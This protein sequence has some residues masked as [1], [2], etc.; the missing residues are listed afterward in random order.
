MIYGYSE[1]ICAFLLTVVSGVYFWR[2]FPNK[3]NLMFSD[4]AILA[5]G[6]YFGLAPFVALAYGGTVAADEDES[7]AIRSTY[8]AVLLFLIGLMITKVFFTGALHRVIRRCGG[9]QQFPM[10]WA[11]QH[12]RRIAVITGVAMA[13]LVVAV[14]MQNIA[15][16]GGVGSLDTSEVFE[17]KTYT[18]IVIEYLEL[19]M[20][21]GLA[22]LVIH[23]LLAG[24]NRDINFVL[25]GI[26]CF[27][28][29]LE[30]RRNMAFFVYMTL[31]LIALTGMRL[32]TGQKLSIGLSMLIL[33]FVIFPLFLHMRNLIASYRATDTSFKNPFT[34]IMEAME[35]QSQAGTTIAADEDYKE[36]IV[37]RILETR[38]FIFNLVQAQKDREPMGGMAFVDSVQYSLPRSFREQLFVGSKGD[39]EMYYGF[40]LGDAA[41]SIPALFVADFAVIGGLVGGLFFGVLLNTLQVVG[42]GLVP[43]YPLITLILFGNAVSLVYAIDVEFSQLLTNL[44]DMVLV[45]LAVYVGYLISPAAQIAVMATQPTPNPMQPSHR[46]PAPAPMRRRSI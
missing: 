28:A 19:A 38:E 18:H 20:Y 21:P 42:I 32:N 46:R 13:A 8:L 41:T 2:I 4:V 3:A 26:L 29:A 44:R 7:A 35:D 6:M 5:T 12:F 33:I 24:K 40:D 14:H 30:G 27:F 22:M 1:L 37:E 36:N 17:Q 31:L 11:M 45:C 9:D 23:N 34:L 43:R 25:L 10:K 15:L 39:M 16:G